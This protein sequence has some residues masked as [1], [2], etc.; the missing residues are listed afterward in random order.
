MKH[1]ACVLQDSVNQGV[2]SVIDR[3]KKLLMAKD[4]K[5][6][7]LDMAA[8]NEIDVALVSLLQ[9]N[10]QTAEAAGQVSSQMR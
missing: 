10:I 5:Q 9:Q 6:M 4:K 2:A 7:I 8:A 1:I 3:M